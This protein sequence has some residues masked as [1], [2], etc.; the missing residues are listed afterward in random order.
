MPASLTFGVGLISLALR[1]GFPY[2]PAL[3]ALI[4]YAF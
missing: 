3:N 2:N 4:L 1:M